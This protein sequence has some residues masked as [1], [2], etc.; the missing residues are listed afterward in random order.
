[1]KMSMQHGHGS[2]LKNKTKTI[3]TI[4]KRA[5]KMITFNKRKCMKLKKPKIWSLKSSI[6]R[7][8][9]S[10]SKTLQ[11][12]EEIKSIQNGRKINWSVQV[13]T[14]CPLRIV[15]KMTSNKAE[16]F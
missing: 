9:H 15:K 1:M 6:S 10:L 5:F 11:Q 4:L 3:G 7:I 14:E 8:A 2:K 16:S 12:K 13:F